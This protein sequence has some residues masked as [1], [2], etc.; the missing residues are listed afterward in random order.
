MYAEDPA[1]SSAALPSWAMKKVM[2]IWHPKGA[3]DTKENIPA[4]F[5]PR[6]HPEGYRK[7]L[8][9]MK[10]AE[11]FGLPIITLNRLLRGAFSG[12]GCR[13]ASYRRSHRGETCAK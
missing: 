13:G 10:M 5:R 3:A 11:K 8:R 2:V 4:Q 9:L 6:R 12:R 7:A 1:P